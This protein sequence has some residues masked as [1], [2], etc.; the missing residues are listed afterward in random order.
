MFDKKVIAI[1]SD[2][3]GFRLK[4][5]LIEYFRNAGR[6]D[7]EII[8]C[9][10]SSKEPTDYPMYAGAVCNSIQ[11]GEAMFGILICGTGVGM[12]MAANK[13]QGI[14]AVLSNDAG[15][16]KLAREHN[17]ANVLCLAGR[18]QPSE[19]QLFELIKTFLST[20]FTFA[21]RHVRRI[22]Q[23]EDS[24]VKV[25]T[26]AAAG[27]PASDEDDEPPAMDQVSKVA[28]ALED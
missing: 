2:H 21:G 11:T 1:G 18:I 24:M 22:S 13:Y 3:A 20:E 6:N 27:T 9:G 25:T 7:I 12:C 19:H 8:D 14:R 23:M 26:L 28:Q 5:K 16:V 4:S 10:C 17:N 15:I